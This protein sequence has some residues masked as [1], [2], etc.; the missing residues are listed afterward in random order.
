MEMFLMNVVNVVVMDQ[1]VKM[2]VVMMAEATV[3]KM[4]V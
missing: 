3:M 1:V 2:M 4:F